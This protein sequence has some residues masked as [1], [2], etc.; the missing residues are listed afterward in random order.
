METVV[1]RV[2]GS[3]L[4]A[5]GAFVVGTVNMNMPQ[6][7]AVKTNSLQSRNH[8]WAQTGVLRDNLSGI[9]SSMILMKGRAR[10]SRFI[11]KSKGGG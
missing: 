6:G 8:G 10:I 1:L 7:M 3:M 11:N 5:V 4:S 2:S 9:G